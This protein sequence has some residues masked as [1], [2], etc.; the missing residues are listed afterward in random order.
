MRVDEPKLVMGLDPFVRAPLGGVDNICLGPR[1]VQDPSITAQPLKREFLQAGGVK[2]IH[3]M[4]PVIEED[5]RLR[6]YD[7]FVLP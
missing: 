6:A 2:A 4:N 7:Q 5:L 1:I 3:R